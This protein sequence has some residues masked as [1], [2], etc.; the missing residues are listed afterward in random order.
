[1][2]CKSGR[3][4]GGGSSGVWAGLRVMGLAR[5]RFRADVASGGCRGREVSPGPCGKLRRLPAGDLVRERDS[6]A[7]IRAEIRVRFEV[8][9]H[10]RDALGAREPA[11]KNLARDLLERNLVSLSIQGGDDLVEA[12]KI[13]DQRQ[14]FT[15]P[16]ESR[17]RECTDHDAAAIGDVAQ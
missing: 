5:S 11:D 10:R 15:V 17:M 13:A 6:V 3:E 8:G 12:Q 9:E 2:F 14:M 4:A 1:M 7:R 16:R